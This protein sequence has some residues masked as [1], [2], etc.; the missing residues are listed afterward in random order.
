[1]TWP[2]NGIHLDVAFLSCWKRGN[3]ID[4]GIAN[5]RMVSIHSIRS[6]FCFGGRF[7]MLWETSIVFQPCKNNLRNKCMHAVSV[8]DVIT[9]RS[10]YLHTSKNIVC[11]CVPHPVPSTGGT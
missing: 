2:T 4:Y 5:A 3:P 8:V 10:M 9:G 11:L 7:G 1:M 6:E